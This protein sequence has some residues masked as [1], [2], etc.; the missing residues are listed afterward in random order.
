MIDLFGMA[1]PNVVKVMIMLEEVE[2]P[3]R[4]T[5]VNVHSGHQFSPEFRALNPNSKTP[6]IVDEAEPGAPVTVF[7]SGAILIY[8]AEKSGALLPTAPPARSAVLQWLMFQMASFGPTAGQAIHF[9]FVTDHFKFLDQRDE[10]A[11]ARFLNELERLI[12]VVEGQLACGE[13][14]AGEGY[15]IADIALFAWFGTLEIYLPDLIDR[16]NIGRWRARLAA[17]P[18]VVKA[19]DVAT[20]VREQA[21]AA[22]RAAT[23]EELD[24]Y[25]GRKRPAA[26]VA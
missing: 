3:W 21:H 20:G 14:I 18:A 24:R 10:Y 6:V 15:S 5:F 7:E 19:L 9:R 26:N 4:F 1:S 23:A 2:L 12:G 11:T 17:R 16:P 25:F 22:R 8:L 13:Y